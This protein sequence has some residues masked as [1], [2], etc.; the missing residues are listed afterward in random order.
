MSDWVA[1]YT[2]PHSLVEDEPT[3]PPPTTM[4]VNA[5]PTLGPD[6]RPALYHSGTDD[7]VFADGSAVAE[8]AEMEA[9]AQAARGI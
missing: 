8:L 2:A 7:Q 1:F 5:A 9:R 4:L 3:D 6:F